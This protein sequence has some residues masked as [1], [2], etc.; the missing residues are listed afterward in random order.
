METIMNSPSELRNRL[1]A[2]LEKRVPRALTPSPRAVPEMI[3]TGIAAIDSLTGGVPLGCLSEVC[4]PASSGRT[5]VLLTLMAG[6]MRRDQIC[7]VDCIRMA[8]AQDFFSSC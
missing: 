8:S 1:E 7:A 3:S 5:S 2:V 6:C 4:G